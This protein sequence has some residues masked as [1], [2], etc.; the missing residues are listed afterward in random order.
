MK[1]IVLGY[2]DSDPAKRA[3]EEQPSWPGRSARR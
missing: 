3:L 2:D 1:T